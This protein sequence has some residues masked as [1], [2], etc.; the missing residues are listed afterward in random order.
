[1][2]S[3]KGNPEREVPAQGYSSAH[4]EALSPRHAQKCVLIAHIRAKRGTVRALTADADEFGTL[5]AAESIAVREVRAIARGLSTRRDARAPAGVTPA[6]CRR[7]EEGRAGK[8]EEQTGPHDTGASWL[9]RLETP[10]T[11]EEIR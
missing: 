6:F 5:Q 3:G 11:M 7:I 4:A 8:K 1:M 9:L 2:N 10:R